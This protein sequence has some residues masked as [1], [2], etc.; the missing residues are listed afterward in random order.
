MNTLSRMSLGGLVSIMLMSFLLLLL[1]ALR[2]HMLIYAYVY[3]LYET[4]KLSFISQFFSNFLP[5]G[6]AGDFYKINFLKQNTLS[7]GSGIAKIGIDRFSGL[8]VLLFFSI[9][10]FSTQ[11]SSLVENI[12]LEIEIDSVLLVGLVTIVLI[13]LIVAKK[14]KYIFFKTISIIKADLF[15]IKKQNIFYFALLCVVVFIIRLLKFQIIFWALGYD[16]YYMDLILLAFVSQLAG[17]MPISIGGLGVV[18]ASLFYGLKLFD[19]SEQVALAFTLLNRA[20]IWMVSLVGGIYWLGFR[21][22]QIQDKN[23]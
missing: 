4:V 15:Q 16:F 5:G 20:T 1:Q 17:M 9:F 8:V 7:V 3:N 6:V 12:R 18:E 22:K 2:L 21:S 14:I 10:Y 11:S 13:L 19:V 23:K